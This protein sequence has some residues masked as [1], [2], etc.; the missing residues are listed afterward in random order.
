[1][2]EAELRAELRTKKIRSVYAFYGGEA[3]AARTALTLLY[4]A[5]GVTDNPFNFNKF[6]GEQRISEVS[7]AVLSIPFA[8][9]RRTVLWKDYPLKSVS[10]GE[11]EALCRLIDELPETSLLI[12]FFETETIEFKR[13][14]EKFKRLVKKITAAGGEAVVFE[15]RS[16]RE[17]SKMLSD[18]ASRRG[19]TLQQPVAMYMTEVCGNDLSLL[20]NELEKLCAYAHGSNITRELVD[21]ICT[22]NTESS[23][24]DLSKRLLA[25]DMGGVYRLLGELLYAKTPAVYILTV[26][27]GSF[28][29]MYRAKLLRAAGERPEE[30]C[31][32]FGYGEN[33]KFRLKNAARDASSLSEEALLRCLDI[34]SETDKRLKT[35]R[36]DEKTE[37]E[38][39]LTSLA[40]TVE[41][42]K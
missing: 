35:A 7:S 39:L 2:T 40:F 5:A 1:M 29:D 31:A 13:P 27:S 36:C 26:L 16:D 37:L 14:P 21:K 33:M 28:I 41:S 42:S 9:E 25:L 15:H 4:N 10:D 34:L 12:F 18:G 22:K 23:I 30:H 19:C 6:D 24:Y 17:V 3:Y 38:M 8:A 11:F 20:L 32:D